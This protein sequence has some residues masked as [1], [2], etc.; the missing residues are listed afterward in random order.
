[1]FLLP[2]PGLSLWDVK[3]IKRMTILL[4]PQWQNIKY[5]EGLVQSG[6]YSVYIQTTDGYV[7]DWIY[8][9]AS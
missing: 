1:M 6:L 7:N 3:K 5:P 2:G 8:K 4:L 9:A